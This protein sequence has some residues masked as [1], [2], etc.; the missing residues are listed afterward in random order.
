MEIPYSCLS[1]KLV[2]LVDSVGFI[3]E[4]CVPKVRKAFIRSMK[5]IVA[6]QDSLAWKKFLL[7]P[8]VL[9]INQLKDRKAI[10]KAT[11]ALLEKDDW[12]SFTYD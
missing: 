7:L 6:T 1:E 11:L 8:T 5:E 12:S 3:P 9:F 2:T 4:H 10:L